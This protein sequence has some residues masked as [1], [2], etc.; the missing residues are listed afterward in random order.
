M[1]LTPKHFPKLILLGFC[2][3]NSTDTALVKVTSD[4]PIVRF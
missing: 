2:C 1:C 3:Q 4:F